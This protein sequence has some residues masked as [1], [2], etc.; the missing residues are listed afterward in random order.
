MTDRL[1]RKG[2][3]LSHLRLLS[4]LHATKKISHSADALGI[5][6]PAASRLLSQLEELLAEK[7][8]ERT[9]HG[10]ELTES[11]KQLAYRATRILKEINDAE[12]DINEIR[13]GMSGHVRIGSVTGP[14]IE[15]VVP[16]LKHLRA[17]N[18]GISIQV[19]VGPSD[20]L[21]AQLFDG[22]LDF[23]ISRLPS[24]Y[25]KTMFHEDV[26]G[27]E[28]VSIITGA[29]HPLA[30]AGAATNL[31][32]LVKLDW[33]LPPSEAVLRVTM[34]R[35]FREQKIALPAQILTTS[36]FLFTI[37]MLQKTNSVA[38]LATSA[39]QSFINGGVLCELKTGI[40]IEVEPYS[41]LTRSDQALTPAAEIVFNELKA[42]FSLS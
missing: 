23:S 35:A 18:P 36:S 29:H 11:G 12:R 20:V 34:E 27:P 8:Y 41:I 24:G 30:H 40:D 3:K 21:G 5:T 37:A 22:S 39:A 15:F 9:G 7:L 26:H 2:L 38:A 25:D 28:R 42:R 10:I 14:A 6:Q 16:A 32:S 13:K 17:T 19:E 33:I 4:S 1:I 31:A